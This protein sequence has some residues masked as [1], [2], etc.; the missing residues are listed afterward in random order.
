MRSLASASRGS[1]GR[2]QLTKSDVVLTERKPPFFPFA[3]EILNLPFGLASD[4]DDIALIENGAKNWEYFGGS[5]YSQPASKRHTARHFGAGPLTKKTPI[6]IGV[7]VVSWFSQKSPNRLSRPAH[8]AAL[9]SLRRLFFQA[10]RQLSGVPFAL[11][12]LAGLSIGS[13]GS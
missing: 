13:P 9:S 3:L 12:R 2:R 1:P 10:I 11:R 7:C 6:F 8:W 5:I 4:P